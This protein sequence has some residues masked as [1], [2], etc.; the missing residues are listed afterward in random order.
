MNFGDA[1]W[2]AA[3]EESERRIRQDLRKRELLREAKRAHL[4]RV[5]AGTERTPVGWRMR[6]WTGDVLVAAGRR[7]QLEVDEQGDTTS[8]AAVGA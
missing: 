1:F 3:C 4:T 8:G 7:L 2:I 6:N 5:A